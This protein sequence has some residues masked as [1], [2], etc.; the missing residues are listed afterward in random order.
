MISDLPPFVIL[1]VG[2]FLVP[3]FHGRARVAFMVL[4]PVLS[5]IHLL[6]LAEGSSW[7]LTV[8]SFDLTVV[9]ID[10][11][12][13][14][15][16]YL[17]HIA[18]LIGIIY[19]LHV[20]DDLQH[21]SALAYA[22]SAL[23]AVF[24][25][26]LITLFVFWE[27]LALTSV[28][29]IWARR[30]ERSYRAGMRYLVFQVGSG[31]L[32][33]A[34]VILYARQTGSVAFEHMSLD[35]WGPGLIFIA[36]GIKCG[37]PFLHNWLTDAYPEA[38]PTGAIFLTAF[39]TKVAVYAL[40]RGFTGAEFHGFPI[41][42][43]IGAAMTA[44]PIFYAVIENDLRRVLAY[45]MINQIGFMVCGI[46]IGTELA[47]NGAV[48]HA[49]NDVIFK[50]LLFMAMGAV[51]HRTGRMNGSDLGGLYK[52]M[53]KTTILC[54]VG[55][56]SISAFPL[57]SG[58]VSKSM[59]MSAALKEGHDLV[60]LILLF[61]SAGVFHHA[62]I[63]I[64][65]FAFF[66]HDSGIRCEE[67]PRNMLA[68]MAIAAALCI[69]IGCFPGGL[70]RLLPFTVDYVPYTSGHVITQLQIL[71]FSA[72]AFTWLKF[73]GIYPPELRSVNL[74][75]DW[76][77]R[78]P[79]LALAKRGIATAFSMK[80]KLESFVLEFGRIFLAKLL[81]LLGPASRMARSQ[82]TSSMVFWVAVMLLLV[83]CLYFV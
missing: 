78:K 82:G 72:L 65:F 76:F 28:F 53:P 13:R 80:V 68:A 31:V 59:V 52:S 26:D 19:S 24:A 12:S 22:G 14:L 32:L 39:T 27:L 8:F 60:W 77:Y 62:G 20:K 1:L 43:Y 40:A 63:K 3:L 61:A 7:Q 37:F 47:V 48:S 25:G 6:G 67:A 58:F 49:F 55:A 45:S 69:G 21:I 34:G 66:S 38:T 57:F 15:F 56:C 42:V 18:A 73:S 5:F 79:M 36:I 9:R 51:L 54:I 17:F 29:L 16:G 23:G 46:G 81:S 44:F 33:L 30:T 41:L 74:D 70:Y 64:P 50:G 71:F 2:A 11:L 75:F 83:L 35:G 4:L 10:R